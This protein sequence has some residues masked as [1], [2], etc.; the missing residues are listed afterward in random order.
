VTSQRYTLRLRHAGGRGGA[1][2]VVEDRCGVAYIYSRKGLR[3]R[4]IGRWSLPALAPTLHRLG[5]VPVP[6]VAPY[7]LEG[8]RRLL[9]P[10]A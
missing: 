7:S 4:L 9:G 2:L 5:W 10:S 6:L 1:G 3:C 8:L